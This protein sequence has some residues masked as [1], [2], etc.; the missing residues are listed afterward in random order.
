MDTLSYESLHQIFDYLDLNGINTLHGRVLP[1][2]MGMKI[3]NPNLNVIGFSGDGDAYAEG[4]EHLIHAA[5]YNSDIKYNH[6][7]IYY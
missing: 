1:A 6:V 3:G 5:R 2:L 7:W 4:M